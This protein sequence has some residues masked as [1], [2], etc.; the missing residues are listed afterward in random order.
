MS[1]PRSYELSFELVSRTDPA[2]LVDVH[3]QGRNRAVE[4]ELPVGVATRM[5]V[6]RDQLRGFERALEGGG[7]GRLCHA[8]LLSAPQASTAWRSLER[9]CRGSSPAVS[10]VISALRYKGSRESRMRFKSAIASV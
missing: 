2:I 5:R 1:T 6:E 4:R 8:V 10:M 9:L 7:C 3:R